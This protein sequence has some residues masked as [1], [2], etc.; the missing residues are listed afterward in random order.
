MLWRTFWII[1]QN[2]DKMKKKI[3]EKMGRRWW[4]CLFCGIFRNGK[5]Q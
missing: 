1:L 4:W 3:G 5:T 2:R